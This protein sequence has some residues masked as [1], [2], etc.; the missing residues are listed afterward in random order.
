MNAPYCEEKQYR[1]NTYDQKEVNS[2]E[3]ENQT[4]PTSLLERMLRG[5]FYHEPLVLETQHRARVVDTIPIMYNVQ[6][7][8]QAKEETWLFVQYVQVHISG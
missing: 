3:P 2:A 6:S 8:D 7:I 1:N 5:R 4:Q